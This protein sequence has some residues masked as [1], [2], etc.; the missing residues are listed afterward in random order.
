MGNR[1]FPGCD[2]M[3]FLS[4]PEVMALIMFPVSHHEMQSSYSPTF[5]DPSPAMDSI[6]VASSLSWKILRQV[7]SPALY[8]FNEW[9]G[10]SILLGNVMAFEVNFP[11]WSKSKKSGR[12]F[13]IH[14]LE[15]WELL[16]SGENKQQLQKVWRTP[17]WIR[18]VRNN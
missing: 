18:D 14:L 9:R 7:D 16:D 15:R 12:G 10:W 13:W 4:P 11:N 2:T 3:W 8:P 17:G 1:G 5:C 6:I